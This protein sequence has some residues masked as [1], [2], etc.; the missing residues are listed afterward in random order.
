[1]LG[2]L[3]D[4]CYSSA[5]EVTEENA[6]SLL[7]AADK[8][9]LPWV[10]EIA[11]EFLQHRLEP[12]NCL[13]VAYLADTHSC[14]SLQSAAESVALHNFSEV[15]QNCVC[16]CVCVDSATLQVVECP[17]FLEL[18][19]TQLTRLVCQWQILSSSTFLTGQA[20]EQR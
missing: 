15:W 13:S 20:T 17:D 1:M 19:L 18:P 6:G 9:Q 14:S 8:L 10:L 3:V 11:C 16:V 4:Y 12:M 7:A 5:V 2:Q